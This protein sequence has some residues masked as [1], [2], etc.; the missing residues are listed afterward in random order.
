MLFR[1]SNANGAKMYVKDLYA[2]E[3]IQAVF[4]LPGVLTYSDGIY[5]SN[6]SGCNTFFSFG[7]SWEATAFNVI[8]NDSN[9]ELGTDSLL[10]TGFSDNVMH[11]INSNVDVTKFTSIF[12]GRG[13]SLKEISFKLT[14]QD[15][16]GDVIEGAN[17]GVEKK[18]SGVPAGK[19]LF[20]ITDV[21]LD[22]TP[23][24]TATQ[25]TIPFDSAHGLSV[26]N[27]FRVSSEE[28][29]VLTIPT[30]T[31]VT[32]T[33]GVN[34]TAGIIHANHG[35]NMSAAGNHQVL[36]I[37][38]N[39]TTD[40]SGQIEYASSGNGKNA[41][42]QETCSFAN[43]ST[44]ITGTHVTYTDFVL[45]VRKSTR[46]PRPQAGGSFQVSPKRR[47]IATSSETK[48]RSKII[49]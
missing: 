21:I 4:F 31:T 30:T 43:N 11:C 47:G 46:Q 33:R 29:T 40:A 48:K 13:T 42:V 28:M 12:L 15:E 41:V 20:R 44:P 2:Q 18:I 6:S 23:A 26:G 22:S 38:E 39:G 32:V 37:A 9:G 25:T 3:L 14:V 19:A 8:S 45:K 7:F 1:S 34:G 24:I 10:A 35:N 27:S 36:A 49:L 17:V 16:N 5:Q